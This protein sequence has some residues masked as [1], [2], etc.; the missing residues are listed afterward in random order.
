M[1]KTLT[2]KDIRIRIG[3][4]QTE[5]ANRF[6][7]P[8]RTLQ[9]WEQGRVKEPPYIALLINEIT[10]TTPTPKDRP[11][12]KLYSVG[13][14]VDIISSLPDEFSPKY[15]KV[16]EERQILLEK[17]EEDKINMYVMES[18]KLTIPRKLDMRTVKRDNEDIEHVIDDLINRAGILGY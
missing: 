8:V 1:E 12:K 14:I 4:K 10:T 6:Q 5:F 13:D 9:N 3:L 18:D 15:L 17:G 11:Y 2:V 7:I 16:N